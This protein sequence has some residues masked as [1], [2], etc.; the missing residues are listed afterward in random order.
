VIRAAASSIRVDVFGLV[1]GPEAEPGFS[2]SGGG[3]LSGSLLSHLQTVS[4]HEIKSA[5]GNSKLR[6]YIGTD[7][8]PESEK[9]C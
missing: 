2:G 3:A 1:A 5:S 9:E 4:G 7:A 8:R 6:A